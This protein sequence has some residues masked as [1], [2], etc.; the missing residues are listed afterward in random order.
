MQ[1]AFKFA[2]E[3]L[4]PIDGVIVGMYP[5]HHDQISENAALVRQFGERRT[6]EQFHRRRG[7][8]ITTVK[9]E[10]DAF[11]GLTALLSPE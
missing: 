3:R 9:V 6:R 7:E 4:K 8:G 2:F 10:H 1:E 5:R 11:G